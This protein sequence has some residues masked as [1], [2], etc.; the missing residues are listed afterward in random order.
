MSLRLEMLQVARLAPNLLEEAADRIVC[1][2][3]EQFN[4]DGGGKD[5]AG[6]SDLYY[7]VFGLEGL[8]ALRVELPTD[9]VIPYLQSFDNGETLDLV[10]LSCLARC[11]AAMP[12]GS[13]ERRT[14]DRLLERI[15]GYRS[16][17]GGYHAQLG[18][19]NGTVYHSFLALGAYQDLQG[20]LPESSGLERCLKNLH[21]ADGAYANG[22][23]M[24]IGTTPATAAA[25]T[26]LRHLDLNIPDPVGEWLVARCHPD[27]GFRTSWDDGGCVAN[28][29]TAWLP[30]RVD[31]RTVERGTNGAVA[32]ACTQQEAREEEQKKPTGRK[33]G[34]GD[35]VNIPLRLTREQ[36]M[37]LTHYAME[38]GESLQGVAVRAI[39]KLLNEDA[40]MDF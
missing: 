33:R 29:S 27:G 21:T 14:A 9:R 37:I 10:H 16:A 1:F 31:E 18:A 15:E 25:V 23:D 28:G 17:D 24:P 8:I 26:V 3:H 38:E 11:W 13:M 4:A 22:I 2:L 7:T 19:E 34:Q 39:R 20:Q 36:W 35:R 32:G 12:K 40:G 6:E 5:R 30:S